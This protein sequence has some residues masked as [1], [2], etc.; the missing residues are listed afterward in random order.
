MR[1]IIENCLPAQDDRRG[2][3]ATE[4][5]RASKGSG[6]RCGA[7][8]IFKEVERTARKAET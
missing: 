4:P 5:D 2:G 3:V 6:R 1:E 8:R 7:G